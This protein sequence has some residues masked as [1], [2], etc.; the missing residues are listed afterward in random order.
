MNTN[1]GGR[2]WLFLLPTFISSSL[3][4]NAEIIV[5]TF[6]DTNNNGLRDQDEILITGLSVTGFDETGQAHPFI[7]DGQ[8]IFKLQLVPKRLRIKVTGYTNQLFEGVAGPTSIFFAKNGDEILVP[9]SK[10]PEMDENNLD[11]LVPCYE[12]GSS[13]D[14]SDSPAFVSFPYTVDGVAKQYGG[15]APNPRMDASIAQIGSTWGVAFQ[16]NTQKAFTSTMLKRHVGL[17]PDGLG[18][19]YTLD[20]GKPKPTINSLNLQGF[21]PSVGPVIDLGALKRDLVET[22]IDSSRPY[23]LSSINESVKRASFDIDAFDKVGKTAFGDIDLTEDEK[24]LWMVN[25]NQRWINGL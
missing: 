2:I 25:L 7:D 5:K 9:I 20:Y 22:E 8:G 11:I 17:G 12:K 4:S 10:G 15:T 14:K 6:F 23:A 24:Q 21:Q 13:A 1:S 16:T 18:S 3:I 19:I